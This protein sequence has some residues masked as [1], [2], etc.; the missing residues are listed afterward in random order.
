MTQCEN[1]KRNFGL[2]GRSISCGS[3]WSS[4]S[5]ISRQTGY[6]YVPQRQLGPQFGPYL[7]LCLT[8]PHVTRDEPTSGD[9]INCYE[10]NTI[11]TF[12]KS[13][14]VSCGKSVRFL[15]SRK[16]TACF[17]CPG[18]VW[19]VPINAR[20]EKKSLLFSFARNKLRATRIFR[21]F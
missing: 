3:Y 8:H 7:F 6:R 4:L 11:Y 13:L 1:V 10:Y 16:F 17:Y 18:N 12:D 5:E 21:Y 19:F 15:N 14:D 2:C 20:V 9:A